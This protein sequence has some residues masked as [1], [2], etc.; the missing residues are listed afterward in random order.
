M[1]HPQPTIERRPMHSLFSTPGSLCSHLTTKRLLS[2]HC[3]PGR[4][5]RGRN[6]AAHS[7]HG[8]CPLQNSLLFVR[9]QWEG[10][11]KGPLSARHAYLLSFLPSAKHA[12]GMSREEG[13]STKGQQGAQERLD[14]IGSL[15][16]STDWYGV[17]GSFV[18]EKPK[19]LL[20]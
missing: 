13:T 5:L 16:E 11:G 10:E 19:G 6:S 3:V 7:C 1:W 4:D 18:G 12:K 20:L 8:S 17:E 9:S 14:G 15:L 2:T